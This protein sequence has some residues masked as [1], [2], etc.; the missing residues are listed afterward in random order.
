MLT[1][2]VFP[3]LNLDMTT[4]CTVA[5]DTA[6]EYLTTLK[7]R[8]CGKYAQCRISYPRILQDCTTEP[9]DYANAVVPCS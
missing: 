1:N 7:E 8:D 3:F 4:K 9:A 2:L 5:A 6:M